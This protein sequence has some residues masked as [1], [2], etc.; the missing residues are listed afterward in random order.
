MSIP[1]SRLS[2]EEL[3]AEAQNDNEV[4]FNLLVG[5]YKDPL[6]NFVF[7]FVGDLDDCEDIVQETFIR[8][9]RSRK[10]YRPVAK[11]STWAYTIATNLAKSHLRRKKLRKIITF[12]RSRDE[13]EPM[14]DLPDENART[15]AMVESSFRVERIQR[16][17]DTLPVKYRE[18]VVMRDVQELTYEE[19]VAITRMPM[20]T[21]KSRIN[22]ARAL[23][24][25]MLKDLWN[26]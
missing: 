13:P 17:L 22:R 15:D 9:Y 11:F 18:I 6:M 19:I 1:L 3:I 12:S 21:V 5:R 23:L 2:D 16:A 10:S 25:D 24:Q 14:Y 20:G 7:R 4:A 8:V 26:E